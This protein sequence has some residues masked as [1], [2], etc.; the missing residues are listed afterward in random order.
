[1]SISGMFKVM[2]MAG[3]YDIR[4]VDR[5]TLPN[6]VEVS[7]CYT[8][9][10]GYE[11]ALLNTKGDVFPVERYGYDLNDSVHAGHDRWVEFAR[12]GIGKTVNYLGSENDYLDSDGT[13]ILS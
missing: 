7:T 12:D 3:N 8:N 11:T 4:K 13:F 2:S 10:Y 9:D 1:M 5:T 6:G